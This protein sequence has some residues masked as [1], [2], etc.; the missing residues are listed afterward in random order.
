[1]LRRL[2]DEAAERAAPAKLLLQRHPVIRDLAEYVPLVA[3]R[4]TPDEPAD[5]LLLRR[6]STPA[7]TPS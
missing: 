6:P 4:T 3:H 2:V 5:R 7:T 1:V